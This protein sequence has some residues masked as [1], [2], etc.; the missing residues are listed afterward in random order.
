VRTHFVAVARF[1]FQG[2][3]TRRDLSELKISDVKAWW[4]HMCGG[5]PVAL[6]LLLLC[7]HC[8]LGLATNV[9]SLTCAAFLPVPSPCSPS[10][11]CPPIRWQKDLERRLT[12]VLEGDKSLTSAYVLVDVGVVRE[13]ILSALVRQQ[14]LQQGPSSSGPGAKGQARLGHHHAALGDAPKA[15]PALSRTPSSGL[16]A[17]DPLALS[18]LT[19]RGQQAL[20]RSNALVGQATAALIHG[21]RGMV[22][23]GQVCS[24]TLCSLSFPPTLCSPCCWPC[25]CAPLRTY[26]SRSCRDDWVGMETTEGE[27]MEGGQGQRGE[28]RRRRRGRETGGGAGG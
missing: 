18:S 27:M 23:V 16:K 11:R 10:P 25:G 20:E 19:G 4:V 15:P 14:D 21:G 22:S 1:E 28:E 24:P 17:E 6:L 7:N 12:R 26:S 8:N 3:T 13:M 9:T 5:C 2:H